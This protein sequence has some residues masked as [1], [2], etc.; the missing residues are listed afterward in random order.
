MDRSRRSNLVLGLILILLGGWFLATRIVPGL[1]AWLNARL[2]WP[3]WIIGAGG[4][5]LVLGLI[6]RLPDMAVPAFIVGGIG[7]LLY[8]QNLS[9]N[10]ESW[11]YVW[12][13][14]PGFAGLG[15]MLSN[16]IKGRPEQALREGG[17]VIVVSL[18]LFVVFASTV[19][20][21]GIL[22]AYWPALLILLGVGML[23]TPLL[24]RR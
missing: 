20:G 17:G 16:L 19:G 6:A 14:I 23:L 4:L 11:A 1:G 9:G 12:T 18:V 15:V 2:S 10:W 21:W 24:R 7:V 13:L 8:W 3:L 5:L 22:G